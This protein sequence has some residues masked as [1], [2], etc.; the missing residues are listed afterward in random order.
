MYRLVTRGSYEECLVNTARAK[1]RLNKAV[2]GEGEGAG[3][4]EGAL[5]KAFKGDEVGSRVSEY[6][7]YIVII[8]VIRFDNVGLQSLSAGILFKVEKMCV[9]NFYYLTQFVRRAVFPQFI[10]ALHSLAY[11]YMRSR[12]IERMLRLGCHNVSSRAEGGKED[13]WDAEGGKFCRQDIDTI[14]SR[15]CRL[16]RYNDH[17]PPTTSSDLAPVVVGLI[18][19]PCLSFMS[20]ENS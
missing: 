19:K 11:R 10:C 2:L 1:L 20:C 9:E 16:V 4:R 12:Q 13:E 3:G 18:V 8:I 5:E 17:E 6:N 15:H 14:L 7:L